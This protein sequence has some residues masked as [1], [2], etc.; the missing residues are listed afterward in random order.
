MAALVVVSSFHAY[1][2][3]VPGTIVSKGKSRDVTFEIKVPLLSDEPSFEGLQKK[4]RYYDEAG[5]KQTLRPEDADEITFEY[6]GEIIRMISCINNNGGN[7]ALSMYKVLFLRIIIDGPLRLYR[8]Y[9]TQSSGGGFGTGGMYTAPMT[10]TVNNF[11]F[12]KGNGALTQPRSLRWK[13][14]MIEYLNDC[15]ALSSL[16]ESKD[17]TRSEVEAI[18]KYYNANC[19]SIN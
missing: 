5:K 2:K 14:D 10:F 17:L 3:K 6:E 4:I 13:K 12:Q 7:L 11:V 19:G 9:Y 8:F 16:I 18:V 15:P 1:A